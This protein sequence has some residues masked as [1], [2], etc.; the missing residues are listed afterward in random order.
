MKG[1]VFTLA[2]LLLVSVSAA[3]SQV[4]NLLPATT[5]NVDATSGNVTANKALAR[6]FTLS[7]RILG[8]M[9]SSP[10]SV[11]AVT[12]TAPSSSFFA[13][14]NPTMRTYHGCVPAGTYKLNIGFTRTTGL[15]T[16]SFTYI[17]STPITVINATDHDFTLQ[18]VSPFAVTGTISNL[19]VTALSKSATFSSTTIPG[20]SSVNAASALDQSGNHSEILPNGTYTV[21]LTQGLLSSASDFTD[22][23]TTLSSSAV[24]SGTTT[25][26][27]T[28]PTIPTAEISGVVSI[29]GSSP[30]PASSF[31]SVVDNTTPQPQT[32]SAG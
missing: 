7:G 17:D 26:N 16:T 2:L 29:T 32:I 28:A 24:V 21:V 11:V 6:C 9:A 10:H 5:A 4:T 12:T 14:V 25:L 1:K 19:M 22:V 3:N 31:L 15:A 8:G 18:A 23:M 20:F 13:N 30:L 27:F